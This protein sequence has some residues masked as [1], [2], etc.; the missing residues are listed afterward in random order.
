MQ[1]DKDEAKDIVQDAFAKLW[2]RR[3]H[4]EPTKVKSY[5]FTIAHHKIIDNYRKSNQASMLDQIIISD[6][7]EQPSV[8]LQQVL[9]NA[10]NCL[11]DIQ[12]SVILLRD[13][14]GYSYEE[15]ADMTHLSLAQ[16][17]VYIFRGRQ[18]LKHYLGSIETII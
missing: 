15:I 18:K 9:H 1:K 2:E 4:V 3:D 11:P 12:R 5:L 14:E 10:L 16:V 13:Y 7:A 17:K 6:H 8:D